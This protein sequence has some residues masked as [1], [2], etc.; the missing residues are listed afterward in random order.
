ENPNAIDACVKKDKLTGNLKLAVQR[1]LWIAGKNDAIQDKFGKTPKF[2][3][4]KPPNLKTFPLKQTGDLDM[5]WGA[6]MASGDVTFAR[7]VLD[8]LDETH[9]ISGDKKMDTII[10]GAAEWSLGSFVRQHELVYR[11]VREEMAARPDPVRKKLRK[12]V[13]SIQFPKM[14]ERDGDFTASLFMM[15]QADLTEFDKPRDEAPIVR[16]KKT[17]KVGDIVAIKVVFTGAQLTDDLKAAVDYDIQVLDP[18]KKLYDET[19]LKRQELLHGKY[20]TRFII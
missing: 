17:A 20:G 2:A 6:F 4:E 13:S 16:Q 15:D 7:R 19:D 18:D 3:Q 10:R 8:L 12:I 1:A 5:M 14:A 11:M 9:E